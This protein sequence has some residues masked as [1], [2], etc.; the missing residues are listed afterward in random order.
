MRTDHS[1]ALN[2][3]KRN[4]SNDKKKALVYARIT[5]DGERAEISLK[6]KINSDEWDSRKEIVKG[7]SIQVKALNQYIDDLR[8]GIK[9]KY[10]LL[11][12][13]TS[14]ITAEII[15]QAY[16]GTHS[17]QKGH[18]MVELLDY[19]KKIWVDKLSKGSFKNY[20]TTIDYIKLYLI[21]R[22]AAA[23]IYLC[24]LNNEFMTEF[25]YYV[26]NKPI[27]KHDPA[28]GNGVAKHIQRFKRIITWAI[29][30]QWLKNNPIEE[31]SCPLKKSKRKK[32]TTEQLIA[33]EE[34][35]FQNEGLT[36]AKE[37]FLFSC[38][39]GFSFADVMQLREEH[40]EWDTQG[41]VWCKVYR[42]KSNELSPIP[43]LKYAANLIN[44][45]RRSPASIERGYIFPFITN[46][47]INRQLKIIKEI[48]D[49][50]I[51][52]SLHVARHTFAKT[53]T[54]KNGVPIET[55][56]MMIG[57]TKITTTM[58]YA[59][60]DEEKIMQDMIG[61]D[62]KLENNKKIIL[63]RTKSHNFINE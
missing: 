17:S 21:Q 5:I 48:C 50:N 51:P 11:K 45:Y 2:F 63:E 15:K 31:Y 44:R 49:I 52:V 41:V 13:N 35:K 29:K 55:V 14:L 36:Y 10:R 37:L 25:E 40:F 19:F 7:K 18:K 3:I 61:L 56:Q 27:K 26:R 38:Y 9:S 58:I 62:D 6:E 60:V 43:L 12:E 22:N 20:K 47:Y 53:V 8:F 57:H 16:L 46:Q 59:E 39:T 54:L 23:D 42:T 4:C 24:E 30:I 28:L 32:L 33:L 34:K 1:F